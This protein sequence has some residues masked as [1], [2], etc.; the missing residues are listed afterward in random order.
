MCYNVFGDTMKKR[1]LKTIPLFLLL[2]LIFIVIVFLFFNPLLHIDL[3]SR[4]I[5]VNVFD[6]FTIPVAN[7]YLGTKSIDEQV[8][9]DGEVDT[10]KVGN[11][12]LT[13]SYSYFLTKKVTKLVV[14]V[15]DKEKPLIT[16]KGNTDIS[17]CP[18][19]KYIEEG[20]EAFDNYDNDLTDKVKITE[21]NDKIVYTV[22]DSSS[23]SFSIKRNIKY[24]DNEGPII[25]LKGNSNESVSLN[26][27]YTDSG[28]DVKDNCDENLNDKVKVTN[29][30]DTSKQGTYYVLYEVTDSSGNTTSVK[31]T[32][33]VTTNKYAYIDGWYKDI[34]SGPTYIKGI[35][36]VN[37]K[38]SLP[39]SFGSGEDATAM[40]ALKKLQAAASSSGYNIP[41]LSGYRSYSYQQNLYNNYYKKDGSLADVYSARPGHSE[42]QTGLGFDVG[43][44]DNNYGETAAGKWLVNNCAKYG[45]ILRYPKGKEY[46]TGYQYEPWHIRYV[47]VEHAT[48]IMEKGITLEEYLG[49]N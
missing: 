39:S 43:K 17:V 10:S 44:I 14:N 31:R 40:A 24:I 26:S 1:K 47:G 46:I 13:Y 3:Q 21:E 25:T 27:K 42:H 48:I 22:S 29:G 45:F 15:V 16:L 7:V 32:V 35:L 6:E 11:Y 8:F 30:V 9:A 28:Y 34:V 4:K 12:V 38:Y 49:V 33:N 5:E 19:G 37:K 2:I 23:N 36:I 41:F 20:Y 18:N